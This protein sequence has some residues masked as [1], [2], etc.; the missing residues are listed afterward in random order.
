[1]RNSWNSKIIE[2]DNIA[3]VLMALFWWDNWGWLLLNK[4]VNPVSMWASCF[5]EWSKKSTFLLVTNCQACLLSFRMTLSLA[6]GR[7]LN[8]IPV[9]PPNAI[10]TIINGTWHKSLLHITLLDRGIMAS[11]WCHAGTF[12]V[13]QEE[14]AI[15]AAYLTMQ[16]WWRGLHTQAMKSNF[17][18][19]CAI[20]NEMSPSV[21]CFKHISFTN[22]IWALIE[23]MSLS[24]VLKFISGCTVGSVNIS[25]GC[26]QSGCKSFLIICKLCSRSN[27]TVFF[28][29]E[30][31]FIIKK[32]EKTVGVLLS[33]F[34]WKC[35][36]TNLVK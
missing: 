3:N 16:V 33:H 2:L 21:I 11:F 28:V 26:V 17:I 6:H 1:M 20:V 22:I 34:E 35:N 25:V 18:C 36:E 31:E 8:Y 9:C 15:L 5:S 30:M 14:C 19:W 7:S 23:M 24:V 29:C 32:K 10:I 4:R 27:I 13:H 12:L